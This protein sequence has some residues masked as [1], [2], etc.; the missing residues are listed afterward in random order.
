MQVQRTRERMR[1]EHGHR[2]VVQ[3]SLPLRAQ[4]GRTGL[5]RVFAVLQRCAV[6][7]GDRIER[8]RM[9]R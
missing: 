3:E 6:E 4:H 1:E 7:Q 8:A 5:Q 9:Q 2:R